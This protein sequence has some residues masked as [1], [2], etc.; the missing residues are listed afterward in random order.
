MLPSWRPRGSSSLRNDKQDLEMMLEGLNSSRPDAVEA[1]IQRLSLELEAMGEADYRRAVDALCSLFYVDTAD[2]PDLEPALDHVTDLLA[3]QGSR[4][5]RILLE[6]MEESDIKSHLYLA[7][8][9]GR[10]GLYALQPLRDILAG[11]DDAY[12]RSFALYALGKMTCPE[13]VRALPEVLEGLEPTDREIRDSAARTVGRMVQVVPR[14]S[15]SNEDRSSMFQ[16]LVNASHSE[17]ATVR[18][19]AI[20]SLGKMAVT[21]LLDLEQ[22]DTLRCLLRDVMGQVGD[23]EER[24]PA[25]IVHKEAKQAL[26]ALEGVRTLARG[27]A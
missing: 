1:T 26:V 23:E 24:E 13:V 16:A 3:G 15:F 8:I 20:R 17:H 9:L 11:T 5:V 21:G 6:R 12:S 7:R 19:K 27:G 18:A 4:V 22:K 25:F 2:R 14:A 10:I